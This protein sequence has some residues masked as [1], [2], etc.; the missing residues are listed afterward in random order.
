MQTA[1]W[2][3]TI[4]FRVR[5]Q[6]DYCCHV[7]ICINENNTPQSASLI[8]QFLAISKKW[9][10]C[11]VRLSSYECTQE[12]AKHDAMKAAQSERVS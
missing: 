8:T 2:L 6:R 5:K 10:T 1:D 9:L 7:L 12:V 4:V 3:W 11:N